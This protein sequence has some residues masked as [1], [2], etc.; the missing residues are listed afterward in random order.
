MPITDMI[1]WKRK[2]PEQEQEERGLQ[3]RQ[4]PYLTFQQQMNRMF[5]DFFRD[6]GL[7]PSP[8]FGGG[9]EAFSPSVDVVETDKAIKVDVELPGLEEKDIDVSISRD[10]LTISGEKRQEKEEKKHNYVRTERSY[11]SFKRSIPLPGEV[12]A[13]KADAVFRKGVLTVT[14]PKAVKAQAQKKITIK[15]Q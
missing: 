1:P 9:W 14:L 7:E 4:D 10:V 3:V 12:D 5:D 8:A 15:A 13:G 2:E 11:G 6:W